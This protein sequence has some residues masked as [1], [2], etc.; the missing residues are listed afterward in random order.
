VSLRVNVVDDP[1]D[2]GRIP[3]RE[4]C[5]P[6]DTW[7]EQSV[8]A[9]ECVGYLEHVA[10]KKM[11]AILWPDEDADLCCGN[12]IKHEREAANGR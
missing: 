12:S 5:G 3:L 6:Y 4:S 8:A 10:I 1:G 2:I 11:G 7:S 9:W